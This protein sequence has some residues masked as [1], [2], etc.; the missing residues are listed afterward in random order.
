MEKAARLTLLEPKFLKNQKQNY[1][2]DK[3]WCE[4]FLGVDSSG[5]HVYYLSTDK[6]ADQ[7]RAGLTNTGVQSNATLHEK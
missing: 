4:L 7:L 5:E 1:S 3:P 2:F 6:E